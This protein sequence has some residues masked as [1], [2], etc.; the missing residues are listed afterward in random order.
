[1]DL[2]RAGLSIEQLAVRAGPAQGRARALAQEALARKPE[3]AAPFPALQT[4]C[5]SEAMILARRAIAMGDLKAVECMIRIMPALD[6][7]HGFAPRGQPTQ[8]RPVLRFCGL[9]L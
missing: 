7:C 4:A 6:R 3:P 9:S 2:L 8:G 1:M 5:L